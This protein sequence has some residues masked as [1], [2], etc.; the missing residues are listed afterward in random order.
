MNTELIIKIAISVGLLVA[1]AVTIKIKGRLVGKFARKQ[2]MGEKRTALI[3][4]MITLFIF[5]GL[6]VALAI[7]WGVH[8]SG[9]YIFITSFFAMVAIGFFATWSVLSNITSS[10]L[11]FFLFPYE[12]GDDVRV[13]GEDIAGK[14][15]DITLFHIILEDE[16]KNVITIPANLAIQKSIRIVA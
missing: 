12:I 15:I 10:V 4:K 16:N 1:Y 6:L 13:I 3:S 8:V 9:L 14:I 2:E 11:I 5:F 7:T